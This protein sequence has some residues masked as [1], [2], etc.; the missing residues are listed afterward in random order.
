MF[1]AI[2]TNDVIEPPNLDDKFNESAMINSALKKFK[3][4]CGVLPW[5]VSDGEI[6]SAQ[7]RPDP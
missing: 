5:N 3:T 7:L 2:K 1:N 6:L 4:P